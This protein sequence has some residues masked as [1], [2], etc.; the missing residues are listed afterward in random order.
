MEVMNVPK[1]VPDSAEAAFVDSSVE[2]GLFIFTD[3]PDVSWL[4]AVHGH[5]A[6]G[7]VYDPIRDYRNYVR[8]R[9]ADRYDA[10]FWFKRTS[11]LEPL[12]MEAARQDELETLPSGV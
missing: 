1:P 8:T 5:R 2:H 7:V 9:L 4:N 10:L 3:R 6:I 11:A 12:H